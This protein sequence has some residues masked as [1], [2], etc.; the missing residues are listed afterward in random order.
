MW[1]PIT[2]QI[3]PTVKSWLN[4]MKALLEETEQSLIEWQNEEQNSNIHSNIHSNLKQ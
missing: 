3:I 1:L 4:N 2:L